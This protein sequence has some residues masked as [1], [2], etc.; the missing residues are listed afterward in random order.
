[1]RNLFSVSAARIVQV[2]IGSAVEVAGRGRW[3]VINLP[4]PVHCLVLRIVRLLSAR[5][6]WQDVTRRAGWRGQYGWWRLIS[7]TS[8]L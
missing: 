5:I 3:I 7:S 4:S 2:L 8:Q 1:M 6:H